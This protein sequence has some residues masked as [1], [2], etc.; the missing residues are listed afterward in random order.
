MKHPWETHRG[1][2]ERRGGVRREAHEHRRPGRPLD[3]ESSVDAE[4]P[5]PSAL[6]LVRTLREE[7]PQVFV[8]EGHVDRGVFTINAQ[9]LTDDQANYVVK[10]IV[11]RYR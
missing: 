1:R 11:A 8:G 2:A 4:H 9:H 5:C 3:G 6:E 10:R 7:N